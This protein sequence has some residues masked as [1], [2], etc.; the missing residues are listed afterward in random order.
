MKKSLIFLVLT[1]CCFVSTAGNLLKNA[2]F[3][4]K[5]DVGLPQYWRLRAQKLNQITF[6]NEIAKLK[7]NEPGKGIFLIYANLPL[8]QKQSYSVSYKVRSAKNS[9]YRFYTEWI[10]V[11]H[12]KKKWHSAGAREQNAT[13]KW[14][15]R[16]FSFVYPD[17][18]IPAYM[19]INLRHKGEVEF[20][21]IHLQ[22][23]TI[24]LLKNADISQFDAKGI[25]LFW[26]RRGSPENFK[27]IKNGFIHLKN[28]KKALYH[29]QE[30]REAFKA[31][32]TYNVA[33]EAQSPDSGIYRCYFEW[34][35]KV[36]GADKRRGAHSAYLHAAKKW[37]RKTFSFTVEGDMVAC[38][39]VFNT[40]LN[41]EVAFRNISIVEKEKNT[42]KH[43]SGGT[44]K[45]LGKSRVYLK[46][47]K[48]LLDV[49]SV[50]TNR[51][52]A[53]LENVMLKK[54]QAYK[55]TYKVKGEGKGDSLGYHAFA[56][57][58]KFADDR[59]VSTPWDDV[60][61][62]SF[63]TKTFIFSVP[64]N[65]AN[66][67]VDIGFECYS[68]KGSVLFKDITIS[69]TTLPKAQQC[70]I[71]LD[72]PYYRNMIFSTA[73]V[74]KISGWLE[75]KLE[76]DQ[77]VVTL[78]GQNKKIGSKVLSWSKKKTGFSIPVFD[79]KVG[80][81]SFKAEFFNKS[82]LIASE[83]IIIE[84]M[85]PATN[86]VVITQGNKFYVN[87]KIFYPIICMNNIARSSDLLEESLYYASR[88]GMNTFITGG[89]EQSMLKVLNLAK[90]LN[91]KVFLRAGVS[92]RTDEAGLRL[93]KH[94]LYNNYTEK[95]RNHPA[96]LGY[97][98]ADEPMWTGVPLKRLMASYNVLKEIDPYH[99]IWIN[100][101]PRGTI[102]NHALYSQ[103]A[104]IYGVDIYPVPYPGN[105]SGLKD[106]RLT[107]VGKYAQRM[108]EAVKYR[109]PIIMCLQGWAAADMDKRKTV[110]T[111]I[112]PSLIQSRFMAY[113]SLVEG[114]YICYWGTD[115]ILKKSF[116][117]TLFNVTNELNKMSGLIA[118]GKRIKG[119]TANN[120]KIL[121]YALE[122]Q[123]IK[124]L[125]ALN[126]SHKAEQS[127]ITTS[128]SGTEA[129][130]LDKNTKV[131][132]VNKKINSSFLPYEVQVYGAGKL[133]SPLVKKPALS[134]RLEKKGNP[135]YQVLD[136][137]TKVEFYK[138]KACWVW[139]DLT[140]NIARSK[141]II[142]K[143]FKIEGKVKKAVLSFSCDDIGTAYINGK[144][145]GESSLWSEMKVFDCSALLQA[146]E[147]FLT[148]RASDAG[149]LPCGVLAELKIIFASGKSMTILSDS[150]WLGQKDSSGRIPTLNE[151][152]SWK[153]VKVLA[154]YGSGAWKSNVKIM[155]EF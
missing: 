93:W 147:N 114:A 54:G 58:V 17:T 91:M 6:K 57:K 25:P 95:V 78:S 68:G 30:N 66:P 100:A 63:Q 44:F 1:V 35:E 120:D 152:R 40:K 139:D 77:V 109:K 113:D 64:A 67:K 138:G 76:T 104:D 82:K 22:E 128:F 117:D 12:G 19:A 98:L 146:G 85:A 73:P 16:S 155:K 125:I 18:N 94:R 133:P 153:K 75:C 149:K 142:G 105:H 150:S 8:K 69:E 140:W 42:L 24:E 34:T 145:V 143:N 10:T 97:F 84:K 49:H 27:Y 127:V 131:K 124:Y 112:Y 129:L 21:E 121:C 74:D 37:E 90:K 53:W 15:T 70:K 50:K 2:D 9:P 102:K 119:F 123:G 71:V 148:I 56:V 26:K 122:F 110:S 23:Y 135:F 136:N 60:W 81:Y 86:E 116:Y 101:A 33:Y 48:P 29:I 103:A 5:S 14:Q 118:Q 59:I 72:S 130:L 83:Q 137:L 80:K 32:K 62:D 28:S 4:Q 65:S 96:L 99:P 13:A 31:G 61:S 20:K 79:L 132:I 36:N 154:P 41:N 151:L 107:C 134:P 51:P 108:S 89:S 46:A 3:S 126:T 7:L 92:S 45:T 144:K 47:A 43:A 11:K 106:K 115:Y 39:I 55:L 88:R 87:G 141:T 111:G 52:G 38:H